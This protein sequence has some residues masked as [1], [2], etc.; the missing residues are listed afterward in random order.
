[1]RSLPELARRRVGQEPLTAG[2]IDAELVTPAWR[3]TVYG[4]PD[5]P[6]GAVDRDAYVVCVFEQLHRALARRDL[7]AR[8]SQRWA[9]P[10]AQLLI[11]EPWVAVREDVLAGLS[12]ADTATVHVAKQVIAWT[13]HGSRP[14]R[15]SIRPATV[16][17]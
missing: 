17:G 2:E 5:L 1:M 13:R 8:P 6:F 16:P 14:P 9:D 3:R 10:R 15:V 11:G 7:L 12:L 4:N